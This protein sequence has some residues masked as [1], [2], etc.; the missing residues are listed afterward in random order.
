MKEKYRM[1]SIEIYKK[2]H[3]PENLQMHMLRVAAC[4]NLIIDNWIGEKIDKEAIIRVSLLH[5]MGNMLKIP[6]DFSED[7]EFKKIR[8]EYFDI[9][10]TNDHELNME[11]GKKEGLTDK[12]LIILDGKRSRKNEE[13]LNSNSFERKICAYCDQRVAPEGVVSIKERLEDAK[14][15]YKDKALSV[16]SDEKKANRLI[17]CSLSIEKQIM[18]YC[19]INP[20]EINDDTIKQY[21]KKLQAYDI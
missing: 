8:K 9:Y 11:I 14:K 19:T 17:E 13:T 4:A 1:N 10:G 5:D 2:Y 12:E 16:W 20:E 15:R 18:Q 7:I 6:E 3:L 21:I